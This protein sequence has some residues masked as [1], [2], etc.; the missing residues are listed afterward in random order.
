[1]ASLRNLERLT[2]G[3]EDWNRWCADRPNRGFDLRGANLHQ[4]Q[5]NGVDLSY[6]DLQGVDLREAWLEGAKLN[7]ADLAGARLKWAVL[8]ESDLT[9]ALWGRDRRNASRRYER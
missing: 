3:V 5:L 8:P 9:S 6:V 2:R 4:A 7:G 1:M